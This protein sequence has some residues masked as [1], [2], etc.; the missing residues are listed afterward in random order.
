MVNVSFFPEVIWTFTFKLTFTHR[1]CFLTAVIGRYENTELNFSWSE[2]EL[3]VSGQ[4]R[5]SYVMSTVRANKLT[6]VNYYSYNRKL[7]IMFSLQ[8]SYLYFIPWNTVCYVNDNAV[9]FNRPCNL[10]L[11]QT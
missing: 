8:E 1:M 11:N 6:V 5:R 10:W 4:W 7:D 2:T 3:N 9:S